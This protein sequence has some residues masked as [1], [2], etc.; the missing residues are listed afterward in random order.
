[1][2]PKSRQFVGGGTGLQ[3]CSTIAN[4]IAIVCLWS[5]LVFAQ[6]TATVA[7]TVKDGQGGV[8]PGAAVTLVSDD[9]FDVADER[10]AGGGDELGTGQATHFRLSACF[11]E[12]AGDS[13][14]SFLR[15]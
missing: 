6:T 10:F 4:A 9:R 8:I 5:S 13:R 11:G 7:G 2:V 12:A 15:R 14:A 1:M 3:P